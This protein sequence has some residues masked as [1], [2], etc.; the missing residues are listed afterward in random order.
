MT[1]VKERK[2]K[3]LA[4][5]AA[6]SALALGLEKAL[7]QVD[8]GVHERCLKAAD[9]TGCVTTQTN[10]LVKPAVQGETRDS[11][12]WCIAKKGKDRFGLPKLVGWKYREN[13]DGNVVYWESKWR[14][15]PYTG[16]SRYIGRRFVDRYY[17]EGV[18]PTPGYSRS[19]GSDTTTCSSY[20][21]YG[22]ATTNCYTTPAP[23]LRIPGSA[24]RAAGVRSGKWTKVYDC[25]DKTSAKYSEEERLE[26]KWE[27]DMN[28][29][30]ACEKPGELEFMYISL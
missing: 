7:A 4:T 12:G 2:M 10:G 21:S 23:T 27:K 9:Y 3:A 30:K 19:V 11:D 16:E 18:A 26:G 22:R 28:T 25:V 17:D 29:P 5:I 14:L 1:N 8:P 13:E 20:G 15:I 6:L 24:G